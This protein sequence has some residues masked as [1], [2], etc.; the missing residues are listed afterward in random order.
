MMDFRRKLILAFIC[1]SMSTGFI[2]AQNKQI[3]G[4]VKETSGDPVVGASVVVKGTTIGVL[5]DSEGKFLLDVP[6]SATTIVVSYIGLKE[7][8]VDVAPYME[9]VLEDDVSALDEVIVVA[10]GTTTRK[11]YTGST[12]VIKSDMIEKNQSSNLTNNLSGKVAGVQGLSSNGQP[13][14]GSTIRIRGIGSMSASNS[15]LYVVDGVP[16]DTDIS[17]INNADIESVSILKDAA[18][19]ALYGARGA[20][21]VVIVTTKRGKTGLAQIKVDAKWGANSRAIPTYNVMTD[22]GMYYETFYRALYNSR[23]GTVGSDAAHEY[24]NRLLLNTA[25]GGLGYQVYT[26]PQG[27]RLIGTNFKLNPKATPGYSDGKFTYIADDWYSEIFKT[28][29]LRQ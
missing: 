1:F 27:E 18:S 17:A 15:P 9:I 11:S 23:A 28:N 25:E 13:G 5:T 6:E 19:A 16:Y 3:T 24:A 29:N 22:P 8:E 4:L 20:N 14:S 10:F 26:V 2:F 7:K 12:A 21:G